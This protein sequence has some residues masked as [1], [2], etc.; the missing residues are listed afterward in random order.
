VKRALTSLLTGSV[1]LLVSSCGE[2]STY[3]PPAVSG[4]FKAVKYEDSRHAL[5]NIYTACLGHDKVFMYD[6]GVS[7]IHSHEECK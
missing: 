6:R 3:A 1:M 7:V 5:N 2:S 4:T